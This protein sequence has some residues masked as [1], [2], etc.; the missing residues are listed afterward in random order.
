MTHPTN[1]TTNYTITG[2]LRPM[3]FDPNTEG[4]QTQ[5]DEWGNVIVDPNQPSPGRADTLFDT[6]GNDLIISGGGDDVVHSFKG[7]QNRIQG[8]G[9][10]D[11]LD[12]DNSSSCII[13][14]G[15]DSDIIFGGINGNSQLFGD[16]Y[17]D[18]AALITDGEEAQDNGLKGDIVAVCYGDNYLYGS[19]GWDILWGGTGRDLIVAGGGNDLIIG[20]GGDITANYGDNY[21]WS[22]SVT[23]DNDVYT[24][25]ITGLYSYDMNAP[26]GD[27]DVIY[28]GTGN[29]YVDAGGGDDEIYGGTGNDTL[30]GEAGYDFIDGGDGDDILIGD[31]GDLLAD[32]LSG[33][34]YIDGGAGHDEIDGNAGNDELFGGADNDTIYGDAGDVYL[35]GGHHIQIGCIEYFY[36]KYSSKSLERGIDRRIFI[37]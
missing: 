12:G 22:F 36:K 8:G 24:P 27:A 18:M 26:S 28:A 5:T 7:G 31:N 29:D 25:A 4:I 2:D 9:G 23:E 16:T 19:D 11:I 20:D 3:D 30:F 21:T 6:P 33:G 14:G 32:S 15:A 1:P 17:G 13:E 35:D 37:S 10:C 34:D